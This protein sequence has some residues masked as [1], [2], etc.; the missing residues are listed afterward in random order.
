MHESKTTTTGLASTNAA[1]QL[2]FKNA[3]KHKQTTYFPKTQK[4]K[5][6]AQKESP[7]ASNIKT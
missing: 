4:R 5:P 6:T 1:I 3:N 2:E 7:I